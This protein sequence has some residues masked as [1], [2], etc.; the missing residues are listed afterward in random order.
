MMI[1]TKVSHFFVK[2]KKMKDSKNF[3][4]SYYFLC[5]IMQC[6]EVCNLDDNTR[7][8]LNK[9]ENCPEDRVHSMS[10]FFYRWT[11]EKRKVD[12]FIF[13]VFQK[14]IVAQNVQFSVT[15]GLFLVNPH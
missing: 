14:K 15:S 6:P 7:E 9:K 4:F 3:F 5:S 8:F 10:I 13:C 1:N 2:M 11:V 12:W